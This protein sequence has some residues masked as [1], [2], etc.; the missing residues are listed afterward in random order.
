MTDTA[1]RVLVSLKDSGLTITDPFA[2]V[3]GRKVFDRNGEEI[4]K[5]D[6]LLFDDREKRIQFLRI[7]SGGFLGIG[8]NHFL[9]PVEGVKSV[10]QYRVFI[11][12]DRSQ[13]T[14]MPTF[15]SDR[16][17]NTDYYQG[18]YNWWGYGSYWASGYEYPPFPTNPPR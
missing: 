7:A 12:R 8:E 6:D 2:D 16:D 17:N 5:V 3:L 11:N 10:D 14:D 13:L 9:V 18:L 4:G 15:A 1:T